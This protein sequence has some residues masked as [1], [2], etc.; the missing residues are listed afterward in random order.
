M[1][2][3]KSIGDFKPTPTI[4]PTLL[5]APTAA[6]T[7]IWPDSMDEFVFWPCSRFGL[8]DR[9]DD[10]LRE[11][12]RALAREPGPAFNREV[13]GLNAC[14]PDGEACPETT[15]W[16]S[17]VGLVDSTLSTSLSPDLLDSRDVF[18]EFIDLSFS[19][20]DAVRPIC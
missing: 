14:S 8:E 19:L 16:I 1:L 20:T 12:V 3:V 11:P 7:D 4:R 9:E 2:S 5:V 15:G 18:D 17:S 13:C 6:S 10:L